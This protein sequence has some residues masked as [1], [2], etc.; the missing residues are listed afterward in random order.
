LA[1]LSILNTWKHV[2][3]YVSQ[4]PRRF[5]DKLIIPITIS[6][7]GLLLLTL[8]KNNYL[9]GSETLYLITNYILDTIA[10][11]LLAINMHRLYLLDGEGLTEWGRTNWKGR[12]TTYLL[13]FIGLGIL[14]FLVFSPSFI[15][16]S[17]I[18]S[19]ITLYSV[20][21]AIF[22]VAF[23]LSS[24]WSLVL[25]A[26][27]TDQQWSIYEAWDLSKNNGWRLSITLIFFQL[28][29][30]AIL[31]LIPQAINFSDLKQGSLALFTY[32][33]FIIL[34]NI[35]IESLSLLTLSACYLTLST[36]EPQSSD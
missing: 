22:A 4:N 2:L 18:K 32:E 3:I 36:S 35:T 31:Y 19:E 14:F 23:Y 1:K 30:W 24:R 8:N 27:A 13:V 26:I 15:A 33:I 10:L 17:V 11:I 21:A 12:E 29:G 28:V 5:I 25:P 9:P 34:L 16:V 6:F 20:M 7:L